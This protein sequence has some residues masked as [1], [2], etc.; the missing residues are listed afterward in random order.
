MLAVAAEGDTLIE[1]RLQVGPQRRQVVCP[2][3]RRDGG[4]ASVL[5]GAQ[6]AIAKTENRVR[7]IEQVKTGGPRN[8]ALDKFQFDVLVRARLLISCSP[9]EHSSHMAVST[10][11]QI[12]NRGEYVL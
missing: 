2:S 7:V 1:R 3:G 8:W 12:G 10:G 4:R 9:P 6:V 5:A 11:N